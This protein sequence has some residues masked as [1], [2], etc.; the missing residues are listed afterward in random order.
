MKI[1]SNSN[2]ITNGVSNLSAHIE[3]LQSQIVEKDKM[4]WKK[5]KKHHAT[6]QGYLK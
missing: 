3:T 5:E 2:D 6:N 1:A 4:S